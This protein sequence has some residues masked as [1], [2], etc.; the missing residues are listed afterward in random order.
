MPAYTKYQLTKVY[1]EI[2][3]E[4]P[5][6]CDECRT[7]ERLSHSHL[8]HKS[9]YGQYEGVALAVVKEN[10]VLHCMSMGNKKGCHERFDSM[11]V[12]KMNNFEKYY[13][14]IHKL[15]RTFFWKKMHGLLDFYMVRD[16]EV[17]RRVKALFAEIDKLEHPHK[18]LS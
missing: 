1:E 7:S 15:D 3:L 6:V 12:A 11:E 18:T 16:L 10:I 14:V 4:R 8:I 13:R 2:A 9:Y 5:H 17:Y